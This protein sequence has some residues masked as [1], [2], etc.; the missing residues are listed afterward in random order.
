HHAAAVRDHIVQLPC[1]PAALGG[2]CGLGA[3]LMVPLQLGGVRFGGRG[4]AAAP[5]QEQGE[6]PRHGAE[7]STVDRLPEPNPAVDDGTDRNRAQPESQTGY[8][9]LTLI[10][11]ANGPEGEQQSDRPSIQAANGLWVG[12]R[13][14]DLHAESESGDAQRKSA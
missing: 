5:R 8:S 9:Q 10:P 13:K 12:E 2:G 14:S 7:Q 4:A 6:Q 11:L 3:L 1:D